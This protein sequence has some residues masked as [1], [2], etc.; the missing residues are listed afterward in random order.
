MRVAALVLAA[1]RGER[2]GARGP[3]AFLPLAGRPLVVHAVEALAACAAI[4]GIVP[5]LPAAEI[6]PPCGHGRGCGAQDRCGHAG[7]AERQD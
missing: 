7:G 3:K 4:D 6:V 2:F 5:V 1:G